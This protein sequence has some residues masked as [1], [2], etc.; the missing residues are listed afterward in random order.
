MHRILALVCCVA[1]LWANPSC[2]YDTSRDFA[3]NCVKEYPTTPILQHRKEKFTEMLFGYPIASPIGIPACAIMTSNGIRWASRAGF[4][5]LT[6]KTVRSAA[7]AGH[8][9]PNILVL[10]DPEKTGSFDKMVALSEDGFFS[11]D[12]MTMANS[13][14]IPTLDLEW[15]L[16]DIAKARSYLLPG[17]ILIVSIIGNQGE[18]RSLEQDFAYL[19]EAVAEAG[20]QV[21]EANLSCPNLHSPLATYKDPKSIS[22]IAEAIYSAA[23]HTPLVLKVGLFDS[24]EQMKE[25]FIAAAQSHVK[26]ICGINTIPMPIVDAAG[27]PA[28][29]EHRKVAGV[30]GHFIRPKAYEFVQQAHQIIQEENLDLVLLST[31]G[32]L[33]PEHFDQFL[34]A[35]ADAALSA[36]G[37]MWNPQLAIEYHQSKQH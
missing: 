8:P 11:A 35:G 34:N 37:A 32:I 9:L 23:P 36:T 25:V 4:D 24:Y 1:S 10:E 28:F 26:G 22:K 30:S 20:A 14:G 18:E 12:S 13:M 7:V 33:K 15:I 2:L 31:G 6:Y 27:H 21:V 17:Q 29:G 5:I 16:E 19:A 3:F